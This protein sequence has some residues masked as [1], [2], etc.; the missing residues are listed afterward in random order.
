MNNNHTISNILKSIAGLFIAGGI[1][2]ISL[3][4]SASN[5]QP[6][7]LADSS[8][9]Q[10]LVGTSTVPYTTATT[11]DIAA[12]IPAAGSGTSVAAPTPVPVTVTKPPQ[13]AST[14]ADGTYTV[15]AP[16]RTPEDTETVTLTV[17]LANDIVT[18]SNATFSQNNHESRR[19]QMQFAAGY[20]QYV[21]GKNIDSIRLS[22]VSGSSLTSAGFNTALLKVKTEA[23]A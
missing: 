12:N 11:T 9:T 2:A 6:E 13:P 14:Y 19:Y 20:K 23:S 8:A 16:Y 4:S 1:A 22:R 21:I 18:A 17:T 15:S 5:K 7:S 3:I 10:E